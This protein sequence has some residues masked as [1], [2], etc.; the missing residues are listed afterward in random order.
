MEKY[1]HVKLSSIENQIT[2]VRNEVRDGRSEART[3]RKEC[4][5]DTRAIAAQMSEY[6][7]RREMQE[8]ISEIWRTIRPRRGDE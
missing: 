4:L 7:R 2:D 8:A 5:E 3:G 1:F 6:P